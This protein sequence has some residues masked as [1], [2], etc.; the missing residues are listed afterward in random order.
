VSR[1]ASQAVEAARFRSQSCRPLA[2]GP[3]DT[4]RSDTPPSPHRNR[5]GIVY[6]EAAPEHDA[7]VAAAAHTMTCVVDLVHPCVTSESHSPVRRE[8]K[9]Q[10]IGYAVSTR[11]AAHML[12]R[13]TDLQF[14]PPGCRLFKVCSS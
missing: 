12:M 2:I 6:R 3:K 13:E 8:R 5:N 9:L 14:E 10:R 11:S 7:G 1:N 4:R